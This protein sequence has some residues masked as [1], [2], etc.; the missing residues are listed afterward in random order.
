MDWRSGKDPIYGDFMWAL[1]VNQN[2]LCREISLYVCVC[3]C[4]CERNELLLH[5]PMSQL[6]VNSVAPK[7]E[8]CAEFS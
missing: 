8:R 4:V 7:E 1:W 6:F 5:E 3:V 2:T